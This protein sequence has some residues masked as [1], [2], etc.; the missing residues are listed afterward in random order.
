MDTQLDDISKILVPELKKKSSIHFSQ[1]EDDDSDCISN[2]YQ[3]DVYSE[4]VKY[5][6]VFSARSTFRY[7]PINWKWQKDQC[8]NLGLI[9][10]HNDY[11]KT[12]KNSVLHPPFEC[13][14]ILGDGI[15][16]LDA[17]HST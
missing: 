1:L 15:V 4:I 6:P 8:K 17:S 16:S 7:C 11:F 14:N 5:T 10:V 9:F 13:Y 3:P 2:N 12:S